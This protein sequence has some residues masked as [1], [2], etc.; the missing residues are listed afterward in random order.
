LYDLP[1]GHAQ[2]GQ[3]QRCGCLAEAQV[4]A[5]A[6]AAA[7]R[8]AELTAQLHA[9]MGKLRRCQLDQLDLRR[10]L[11]PIRWYDRTY[12]EISQ[13]QMLARAVNLARDYALPENLYLYGPNGTGK[14]HIA[15]AILNDAAARGIPA[16]YGSVLGLLRL[17]R[18][19]FKDGSADDRLE[20]L[21]ATPLLVVDDLGSEKPSDWNDASIFDLLKSRDSAERA[22]IITSNLPLDELRDPRA[23]SLIQGSALLVPLIISDYRA[24]LVQEQ[25][26]RRSM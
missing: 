20:A 2:F 23:A 9:D 13:Y 22:T 11:T 7:A 3:L 17:L 18:D 24:L 19:G 26:P 10:P 4:A 25:T 6:A 15:A 14:S 8:S 21:I 12:S 1:Y 16:R 5:R